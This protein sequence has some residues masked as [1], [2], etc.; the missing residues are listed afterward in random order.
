MSRR[1]SGWPVTAFDVLL[2]LDGDPP[3]AVREDCREDREQLVRAPMIALLQDLADADDDYDDFTVEGYVSPYYGRWQHQYATIRIARYV[4]IDLA[5]DLDGLRLSARWWPA[6][7]DQRDRYRAAVDDNRSGSEL[8]DI[9]VTLQRRGCRISGDLMKRT[10]R[11]YCADHPRGELLRRRSLICEL[12]LGCEEWLHTPEVVERVLAAAAE[13]E[14]LTSWLA[15]H[16]ALHQPA[17]SG[18]RLNP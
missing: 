10:P 11:D 3:A 17:R 14:P 5:F 2:E 8:A 18:R 1:F 13:L 9:V 12:P 16:V 15:T 6:D 7:A 4:A